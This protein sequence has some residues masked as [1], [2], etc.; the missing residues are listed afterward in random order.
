MAL[1]ALCGGLAAGTNKIRRRAKPIRR[2]PCDR[3]MCVVDGIKS[4]AENGGDGLLL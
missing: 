3:Q 1:A 2:R 4:A